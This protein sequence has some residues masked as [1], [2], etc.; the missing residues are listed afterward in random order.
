MSCPIVPLSNRV[1]V[2]LIEEPARI[3]SVLLPSSVKSPGPKEAIVV[4]VG[5]GAMASTGSL[6][7]MTVCTGDRVLL[8][9]YGGTP[10]DL[11]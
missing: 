10:I 11:Q 6:L 8:S 3:G 1:L 5:P 7:P 9:G 2:R 4:A